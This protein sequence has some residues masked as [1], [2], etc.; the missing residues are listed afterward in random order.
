MDQLLLG[1]TYATA[2]LLKKTGLSM[3]DIGVWEFHEVPHPVLIG[4]AAS[5]TPY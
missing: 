3:A 5:L 2:K 1:P 4:H